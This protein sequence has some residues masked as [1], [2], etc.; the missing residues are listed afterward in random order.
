[1]TLGS[2]FSEKVRIEGYCRL[3]SGIGYIF[4][5][6]LIESNYPLSNSI[7]PGFA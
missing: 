5:G 6:G 1:M 3:S 4:S 2:A 7:K